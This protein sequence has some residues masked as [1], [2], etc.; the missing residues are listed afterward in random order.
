MPAEPRRGRERRE[1]RGISAGQLPICIC[2]GAQE[3]GRTQVR[4]SGTMWR[5]EQTA[6]PV[7][8]L[9]GR[10]GSC[11]DGGGNEEKKKKISLE[12]NYSRGSL[13]DHARTGSLPSPIQS[14]ACTQLARYCRNRAA[15]QRKPSQ[16][17]WARPGPSEP[18]QKRGFPS[19]TTATYPVSASPIARRQT[20][21]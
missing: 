17:P 20:I 11:A 18:C 4:A 14:S 10:L 5:M 15:G 13:S 12:Q 1:R 3:C 21:G 6:K 7:P 19:V 9:R 16:Q 8:R 2:P